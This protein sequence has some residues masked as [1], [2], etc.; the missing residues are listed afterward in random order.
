MIFELCGLQVEVIGW[1]TDQILADV[2]RAIR[3][4]IN[5]GSVGSMTTWSRCDCLRPNYAV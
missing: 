3:A 2:R 1:V 5:R 4:G